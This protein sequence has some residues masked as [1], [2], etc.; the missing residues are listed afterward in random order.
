MN[1][2]IIVPVFNTSEYLCRCLDSILQQKTK[3]QYEVIIVND[4]STDNSET[5][6]KNYCQKYSHFKYISHGSNKSLAVARCTGIKSANGEYVMHLDSDDWLLDGAIQKAIDL[7][8]NNQVD[9]VVFKNLRLEGFVSPEKYYNIP[10]KGQLF[11]PNN[12]IKVQSYFMGACWNKIVKRKLLD[13]LVFGNVYMNTSEDLV[14]SFE[15]FLKAKIIYTT[16][17]ILYAY[18]QN[19]ESLTSTLKP[20]HYIKAQEIVFKELYKI[21]EKYNPNVSFLENVNQ[22]K[23]KYLFCEI[24]KH[25]FSKK[26]I[27]MNDFENFLKQ[28]QKLNNTNTVNKLKKAY[29]NFL[30]SFFCYVAYFG[31]L[32][33][34]KHT[35]IFYYKS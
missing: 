19:N 13:D 21:L 29:N 6:I 17:Q 4:G 27:L 3:Y 12:K 9:V 22:Y 7:I 34:L 26:K 2:S 14:Y 23:R 18:F 31:F 28:Y 15:I 16:N 5:I 33:A 24:Y 35:F 25:H 10:E 32:R 1:L 20:D 30:F 11:N 8:T